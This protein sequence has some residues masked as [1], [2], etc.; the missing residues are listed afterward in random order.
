MISRVK[1]KIQH[2]RRSV[3]IA[4]E[5]P[6]IWLLDKVDVGYIQIPKVAT[7]SIQK[8]LAEKYINQT[9]GQIPRQ[10]S[11]EDIRS[12]ERKTAKHM[13]QRD[14]STVGNDYFLFGFV[15]NPYDRL[16]SAYKNK[17]LQPVTEN[18]KN[19]FKNHG[20]ELGINFSDFIEK[21]IV[22]PDEKIDRHLRSQ[23]WFLTYEGALFTDF[24]GHLETFERDWGFLN[25]KF[26]LGLPSHRNST[27]NINKESYRAQYDASSA[28]KVYR[29]Y[30]KDFELFG[31]KQIFYGD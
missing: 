29:R 11:K 20:I 15:R 3:K 30:Q 26:S 31:Y 13:S 18:K 27:E 9:G 5:K 19:I 22:I 2:W 6:E 1:D 12:I 4:R 10:W 14:I 25:D 24:V 7:R 16:Y 23:S 28:E 8:C 21:I 17:V